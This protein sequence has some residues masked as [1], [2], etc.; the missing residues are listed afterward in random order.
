MLKD[1]FKTLK[2]HIYFKRRQVDSYH[3]VKASV[4][5]N[6]VMLQ[7]DFVKSNKN[8]QKDT[9]QSALFRN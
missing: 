8:D 4:S 3:E 2:E 9:M 5:E 1:L 6:G 7:V